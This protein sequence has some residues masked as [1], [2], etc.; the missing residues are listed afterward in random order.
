MTTRTLPVRAVST[1]FLISTIWLTS[2]PVA[3]QDLVT[4]SSLGGE[5][6][7]VFRSAARTAIRRS[8]AVTRPARTKAQQRETV[9]SIKK[10]YDERVKATPQTGRAT[11]VDPL[12]KGTLT[13]PE[14]AKRF[15]GIGEYYLTKND[16]EHAIESFNDAR[17]LD[18]TN[19]PAKTGLSEALALKGHSLLVADKAE[20]AKAWFKQSI[21]LNPK[22]S[23]AYFG[24]GE[25]YA[26]LNQQAEAIKSYEESLANNPKLTE[27]Y[28]PLG[29]LYYQTGEI[30]KADEKLTQALQTNSENAETQFFTGLVRAS[31]NRNDEALT[32]FAIAKSLDPKNADIFHNTGEVLTRLKRQADAV[33]E[34]QTAVTLKPKYFE[35]WLGLGDAFASLSRY[36]EAA[37]AYGEAKK[38]RNDSWEA[39][40]GL[41]EAY[42]QTG[43][44]EEAESEF[45]LAAVFLVR[46]KDYNKDTLAELY[47]KAGVAISQQ[48]DINTPKQIVCDWPLAITDFQKSVDISNNPIDYVNLG[49]AYFRAGHTDAENKEMLRAMPNLQAA[50]TWLEKA[51]AGG[52]PAADFASG[53][54]ASVLLDL[55]DFRGA[56]ERLKVLLDKNPKDTYTKYRLG[57]A[58]SK[59][60]DYVNAEKWLRATLD[61]DPNSV[62]YLSDLA[63]VL[64]QLKNGKELR[65]VIARIR[66]LDPN[67]ATRL[68]NTAKMLRIF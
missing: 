23:A 36:Q 9:A 42:R 52:P 30:A 43:R 11:A 33:A 54:L 37:V 64:M 68:E 46:V 34:Y 32:A 24:L 29:I 35:A 1:L 10:Q 48:C 31:Q 25:V 38:W 3:A 20:E 4:Y 62:G 55:G 19:Q 59:Q 39:R 40:A 27:I 15:A 22:N 53:N 21:D 45:K 7:F 51:I 13:G 44:F 28:V 14:G 65:K 66:P 50:K 57:A 12:T 63:G 58:Y 61:D 5:S 18:A 26:G 2:V 49:T 67:V 17:S 41:A 47:S 60:Q 6:V 8:V 56:I 16:I